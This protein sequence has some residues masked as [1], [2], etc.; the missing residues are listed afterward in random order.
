MF[1]RFID[2]ALSSDIKS[3][4]HPIYVTVNNT[5]DAVNVFDDICYEK[6][7]SFIKM[8]NYFIGREAFK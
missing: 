8:M 2:F 1:M 6:G 3:S 5:L 7:A 4:T